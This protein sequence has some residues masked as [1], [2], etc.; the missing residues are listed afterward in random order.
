[1]QPLSETEQKEAIALIANTPFDVD[2]ISA[3]RGLL[4]LKAQERR[5]WK[6]HFNALYMATSDPVLDD[7]QPYR[8]LE[9]DGD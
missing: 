3:I 9:F 8:A 4:R 5:E 6:Q 1:M 7:T 2:V